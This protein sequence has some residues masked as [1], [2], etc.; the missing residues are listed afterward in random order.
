MTS[1][2]ETTLPC[3]PSPAAPVIP[4]TPELRAAYLELSARYQAAFDANPDYA[5]RME[6]RDWKTDVDNILEKDA[7][8]RLDANTAL[9]QAILGQIQST[10]TD[11]V[12]I[13]AKISAI[14][15]DFALVGDVLTAI[16]KVIALVPA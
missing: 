12:K 3:E 15:G 14:A 8:Y 5:F 16:N 11:L 10:S 13:K 1:S 9:L 4:L 7:M 2:T 6:V